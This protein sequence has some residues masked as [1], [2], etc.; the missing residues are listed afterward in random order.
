MLSYR[1]VY[2][3]TLGLLKSLTYFEDA[4]DEPDPVTFEASSWNQVKQQIITSVK[5]LQEN[6]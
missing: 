6:K 2:P 5:E 3:E 1:T 4:E